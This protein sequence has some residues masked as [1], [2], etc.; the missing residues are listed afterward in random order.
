MPLYH[1]T[2]IG[3]VTI[4]AMVICLC[5]IMVLPLAN[6][7]PYVIPISIAVT[8]ILLALF[9]TLTVDVTLEEV[10]FWFGVGLI[11]KRLRMSDIASCK[12]SHTLLPSYGIHLTHRGWLYN[13][14]GFQVAE[15]TLKNGKHILLGT[16]EAEDVCAAI[17]KAITLSSKSSVYSARHV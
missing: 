16:D 13:V 9:A 4:I 14:S 1:H 8:A 10:K 6:V 11:R 3:Y 5:V 7:P 17:T 2:Q 15:L 12:P